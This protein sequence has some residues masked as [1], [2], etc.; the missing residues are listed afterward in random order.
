MINAV[1]DVPDFGR[2]LIALFNSD[3]WAQRLALRSKRKH[4]DDWF[5]DRFSLD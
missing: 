1:K 4:D 2:A 5:F 3:A